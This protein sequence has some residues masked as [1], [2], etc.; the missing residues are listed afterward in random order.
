[1][2]VKQCQYR[3]ERQGKCVSD[4][5]YRSE[6]KGRC[7]RQCVSVCRGGGGGNECQV[8]SG[9]GEGLV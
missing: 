2:C 6:R 9:E 7:V 8:W 5:Q 4:S 1:M 3:S